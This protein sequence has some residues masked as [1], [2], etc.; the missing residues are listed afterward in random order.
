MFLSLAVQVLFGI[1]TS[2]SIVL[3]VLL[4]IGIRS[5]NIGMSD[6]TPTRPDVV[7]IGAFCSFNSTIGKAAKIAIAAAVDDVNSSSKV[8]N[9]TKLKLLMQDTD[10]NVFLGT[11]EGTFF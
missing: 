11:V 6:D 9:G 1:M 7:S 8:L 5:S 2:Q 4:V 10:K 3:L